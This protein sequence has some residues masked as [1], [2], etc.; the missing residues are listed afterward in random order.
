[1]ALARRPS[2]SAVLNE[3][4]GKPETTGNAGTKE[5]RSAIGRSAKS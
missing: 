1:M 3:L 2:D 4:E 5:K